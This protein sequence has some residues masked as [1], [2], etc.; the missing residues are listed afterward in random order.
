MFKSIWKLLKR[1][2]LMKKQNF[3]EWLATFKS[4]ISDYKYYIDFDTVY[5]R[6]DDIKIELNILNT[7]IASK[8]IENDFE[9]L[10][11]EYPQVLRCI[12]ILL[13]VRS[14]EIHAIDANGD[15]N[16]IFIKPNVSIEQYKYFM[17][18]TGLFGLLE[19]H[20]INNL[21][22]YVIGVEVG[23]NTNARKNRG[24]K[25]MENLLESF[26]V[27]LEIPYHKEMNSSDL[28][29]HFNVDL[30]SILNNGQTKKRFDFVVPYK[31]FVVVFETNFYKSSGSKLNE[32]ARSYKALEED[33]RKTDKLVF[34]WVTDGK[35]WINA[36]YNLFEA[37]ESMEYIFNIDD[38]N[39]GA[40]EQL[41]QKLELI[42]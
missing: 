2:L 7:L 14:H 8:E 31:D 42:D 13:A 33:I 18:E 39:N 40:L 4:S 23:L 22:D 25:L 6:V 5:G 3:D 37:F 9:K 29:Q 34:V 12:P 16:Y 17:R 10:I 35:G 30:S 28:N 38:L 26:F 41:F 19:N 36:R 15:F 20:L 32:T 27:N 11:N 24:G 1:G 21:V